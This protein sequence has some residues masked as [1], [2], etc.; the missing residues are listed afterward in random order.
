VGSPPPQVTPEP[1]K[2]NDNVVDVQGGLV[3]PLYIIILSVIGGAINMTRKVPRLQE[4]G[5]H[6]EISVKPAL[7]SML[8]RL[9]HPFGGGAEESPPSITPPPPAPGAGGATPPA[10]GPAPVTNPPP[11]T[12]P[13]AAAA[14]GAPPETGA[15]TPTTPP[16]G[17]TA[18]APPAIPPATGA[19]APKSQPP[20]PADPEKAEEKAEDDKATG[21]DTKIE[22]LLAFY[23]KSD[24]DAQSKRVEIKDLVDDM[25]RLFNSSKTKKPILGFDSF[26]EWLKARP[27]LREVLIPHWRVEL[28]YQ[29]MYLMS[30]PFLAIVAYYMLD[31]LG[32]TK[33]PI[34]VLISFSV[35]LISEKILSWL[36][37]L[38]SGYLRSEQ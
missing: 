31:L 32:L 13:N 6:S 20:A 3:I 25:Q 9:R 5:E 7:Q 36:L 19:A 28:L 38:A 17:T 23:L 2:E 34:L 14:G 4:E 22:V 15:A 30:A 1:Q 10:T 8:G 21:I 11:P 12:P 35:G 37:G 26:D 33:Q 18:S 24:S 27:E 16:P 29:Y